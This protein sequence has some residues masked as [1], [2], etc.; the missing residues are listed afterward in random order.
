MT[1]CTAST[2]YWF[3]GDNDA[4]VAIV[5]ASDRMLTDNGLGIEYE[6]SHSKIAHFGPHHMIMVSGDLSV[7]SLILQALREAFPEA[8]PSTA[9]LAIG[10]GNVICAVM[11]DRAAR[12][13]LRPLGITNEL[14]QQT[15]GGL[16]G[17][18]YRPACWSRSLVKCSP[19]ASILRRWS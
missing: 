6:S 1:V 5:T 7:N 12:K 11:A 13:Y 8:P 3:Y 19:R 16:S 15:Q 18:A 2:F 10:L 14:I 17:L 4:A 9:L